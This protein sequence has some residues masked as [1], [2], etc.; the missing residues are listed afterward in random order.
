MRKSLIFLVLFSA[1]SLT[2][3][4]QKPK[5]IKESGTYKMRIE[6]TMSEA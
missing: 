1:F 3:L 2:A 5:E 4:A 6:K